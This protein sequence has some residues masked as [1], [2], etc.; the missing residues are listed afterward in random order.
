MINV[1]NVNTAVHPFDCVHFGSVK[2][3]YMIGMNFEIMIVCFK[4]LSTF[5]F[6]DKDVR[7]RYRNTTINALSTKLEI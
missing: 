3:G 5:F 2:S 4:S 6:K 1:Y 7:N